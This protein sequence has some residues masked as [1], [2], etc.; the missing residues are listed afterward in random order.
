MPAQFTQKRF[1]ELRE[2]PDPA[3]VAFIEAQEPGK[4]LNTS[5]AWCE[6]NGSTVFPDGVTFRYAWEKAGGETQPRGGKIRRRP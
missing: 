3:L 6:Y 4:W 2:N 5:D 1:R